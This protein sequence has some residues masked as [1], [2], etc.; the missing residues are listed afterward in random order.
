MFLKEVYPVSLFSFFESADATDEPAGEDFALE[1]APPMINV[2]KSG[3]SGRRRAVWQR[4][5]SVKCDLH[6]SG[7]GQV[8]RCRRG[9]ALLN[10]KH[11]LGSGLAGKICGSCIPYLDLDLNTPFCFDNDE[12]AQLSRT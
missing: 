5:L 7:L 3:H 10:G 4:G 8:L 6:S 9:K 1:A 11:W 2:G 12:E